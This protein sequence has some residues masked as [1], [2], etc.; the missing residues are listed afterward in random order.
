[1]AQLFC[2]AFSAFL[3]YDTGLNR[4]SLLAVVLTCCLTTTS[5]LVFGGR[6][7]KGE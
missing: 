6:R 4:W 7:R 1:M 5:V 2:A 3:L